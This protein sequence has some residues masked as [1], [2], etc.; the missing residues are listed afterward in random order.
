MRNR[1]GGKISQMYSEPY[2]ITEI[3][4]SCYTY[5]LR[6]VDPSSKGKVKDRHFNLLKA[7]ERREGIGR[8]HEEDPGGD[9]G[10]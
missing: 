8:P 2:V 7:I 9:E 10:P 5:R 3:K 6:Q 1:L 4:G